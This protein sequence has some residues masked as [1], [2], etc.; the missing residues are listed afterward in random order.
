MVLS[1]QER[2][3]TGTEARLA[4]FTELVAT[5]VPTQKRGAS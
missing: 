3:P 5:A 2:L 4:E 1:S